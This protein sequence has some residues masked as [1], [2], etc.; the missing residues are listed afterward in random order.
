MILSQ[1]FSQTVRLFARLQGQRSGVKFHPA[2]RSARL[3]CSCN[4]TPG[5]GGIPTSDHHCSCWKRFLRLV[6]TWD[7]F[8]LCR[9]FIKH[10]IIQKRTDNIH[11]NRC[12]FILNNRYEL[13]LPVICLLCIHILNTD[14]GAKECILLPLPT[15][16]PP[17]T[18]QVHQSCI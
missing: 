10:I 8:V 4:R 9:L 2:N 17:H 15:L 14:Q 7:L 3:G 16:P 12:K 6:P 11:D 1:A 18:A 5:G 13:F